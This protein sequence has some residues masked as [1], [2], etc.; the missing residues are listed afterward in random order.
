MG[1]KVSIIGGGIAGLAAG[2]Y[3]RLNGFDAEIFESHSNSGGVCTAWKR[4]DYTM[5]G[6][7]DWLLGSGPGN[8]FYKLWK[9]L[10]AFED[11]QIIDHEAFMTVEGKDKRQFILYGDVDRLE[12]HM[13]ELSPDDEK[14]TR[15]L[16]RWIRRFSKFSM[17]LEKA[18]ELFNLLDFMKMSFKLLPFIKDYKALNSQ[19]IK[20]FADKFKDPLIRD[21][22]AKPFG[23]SDYSLISLVMVM[24]F[25]STKSTGYIRG[26]SLELAKR[27]EKKF[28][29]LGGVMHL[30][31][32]V[33]KVLVEDHK[34]VGVRLKNGTVHRSDMVI[35][36]AD[37]HAT[38]YSML[39][40][41]YLDPAHVKLFE[42]E[43]LSPSCVQVS[44][45]VNMEME[46]NKNTNSISHHYPCS[47]TLTVGKTKFDTICV[48]SFERDSTLAPKGKTFIHI[49][50]SMNEYDYW[51]EAYT[52]KGV[53]KQKK[54]E[55]LQFTLNQLE[56]RHPGITKKIEVSDVCTPMTYQRYASTWNG[57]YMTWI[58]TPKNV[59]VLSS[60]LPT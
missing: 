21:S 52:D 42:E 38:L 11:N 2:C 37:M 27:I 15:Q 10:D 55:I 59:S 47:E 46:I 5:D 39:A 34:A 23:V 3:M 19:T 12:A 25:F 24:A 16:C 32:K 54:K 9:E 1:K 53:Y 13:L 57:A 41:K 7:L 29:D 45:G 44:L 28:T 48:R 14:T 49:R 33:D 51:K 22:L 26:G 18:P 58:S 56:R 43:T 20:E 35:S 8:D 31:S 17:P 50:Y 30:N 36:A 6:C 40:G 4:G 60:T